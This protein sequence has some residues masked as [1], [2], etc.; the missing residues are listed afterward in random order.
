MPRVRPPEEGR[1]SSHPDLGARTRSTRRSRA[2]TRSPMRCAWRATARTRSARAPCRRGAGGSS[3]PVIRRGRSTECVHACRC[4]GVPRGPHEVGDADC[5]RGDGDH[6]TG[7]LRRHPRERPGGDAHRWAG[8]GRRSRVAAS[9]P[10]MT[11]IN[12]S[13]TRYR[14]TAA[15]AVRAGRPYEISTAPSESSTKPRPPGSTPT[16]A[17]IA[18]IAYTTEREQ[19]AVPAS[20]RRD[21]S[22]QLH[23]ADR[24]DGE[25][26]RGCGQR[27]QRLATDYGKRVVELVGRTGIGLGL[28]RPSDRRHQAAGQGVDALQPRA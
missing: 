12:S 4:A 9:A 11:G 22:P 27:S 5:E 1:R 6:P 23:D 13:T 7:P 16:M 28:S 21:D 10:T 19:Q 20:D 17:N 24:L 14:T 15:T 2:R 18:E 26:V 8:I 25:R 3:V